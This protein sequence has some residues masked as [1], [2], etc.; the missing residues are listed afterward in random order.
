M[1]AGSVFAGLVAC[2]VWGLAN[3]GHG[4]AAQW[5]LW[6]ALVATAVSAVAWLRR[7]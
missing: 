2:E 7:R 3:T 6:A 4:T 5:A 1:L